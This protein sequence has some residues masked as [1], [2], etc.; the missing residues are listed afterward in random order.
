MPEI[1]HLR[2]PLY[3]FQQQAV[4]NCVTEMVLG[5]SRG[6]IDAP[7]GCGKTLICLHVVNHMAPMGTSVVVA[8]TLEL[9]EQTARVW[10][11]EGRPGRYLALSG[12][13]PPLPMDPGLRGILT[14]ITDPAT[15]AA[16]VSTADGPVSVFATYA[17]LGKIA[18][19]HRH[20]H[21]P[22]WDMLIADEAHRTAGNLGK[23]WARLLDDHQIFAH[24]RLYATAT[25]R[26]FEPAPGH[27]LPVDIEVA[28]MDD[29]NLYGPVLFRLSL[30]DAIEMG[31]L[32]D[33]RIVAVEVEDAELRAV[34]NKNPLAAADTEGLRVGG[35]EIALLRAL[36]EYDLRRAL[37]FCPRIKVAGIIAETLPATAALMPRHLQGPLQV[38]TVNGDQNRFDRLAAI[39]AFKRASLTAGGKK[40]LRAV[41]TNCMLFAEGVDVP[42]IDSI[43]FTSPKNSTYQIVQAVGRALRPL[44]GTGKIAHIIIPVYK[45]PDEDL[46]DAVKGTRFHILHQVLSALKL[47]DEHVFHR[48]IYLPY[49]TRRA[50]HP[51]ARPER[52]DELIPLLSLYAE[53]PHNCIWE[54][55]LESAT[56]YHEQHHH[57]KVPSRYCGPDRFYLGWWLGNQRSLRKNHSLQP[58]RIK[59]L[60]ALHME[61]EHPRT[62]IEHRL[63]IAR[64][65]AAQYGHLSPRTREHF[66]GTDIGHWMKQRRDE[67]DTGDLPDCYQRAL[68]EI[69][70]WWN[71]HWN[72]PKPPGEW[73]RTYAQALAAARRGELDF[74]DLTP[75][76]NDPPLTRWLDQQ[77]QDLP[78]LH[79][80]QHNLLGALSIQ[81]PLALLLRPPRSHTERAFARG[82]RHAHAYWRAHQNLDVPYDHVASDRGQFF[83]LGEW[84]SDKR[85]RP[86]KLT[87]EQL[88]ALEAL[89]M[90][91]TRAH[92]PA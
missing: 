45:A 33:Y 85:L 66:N 10:H 75:D 40:P 83:R 91:W 80:D 5:A 4:D 11:T 43:L 60:D 61:W 14:G 87:R 16:E 39:D 55:G 90:R 29:L 3:P 89:D 18:N 58:E 31:V 54:L 69:N 25:P 65:Y 7:C 92:A 46:A 74:P 62:S 13:C 20:F 59:A 72:W 56:R 41:L 12:G 38:G 35:A 22:P 88:D 52:V 26:T 71:A 32:A 73:Q 42:A 24:H 47:Y 9:L 27:D 28:S 48:V 67:A 51:A 49:P 84:I 68:T 79:P 76:S 64:A 86:W 2:T 57:L 78:R 1:P 44:P 21:M 30:S 63:E 19:A 6:R 15:L 50:L 37:V 8:P 36:G 34:L 70:P 17:S 82:L 77:L 81:H 23:P 53:D